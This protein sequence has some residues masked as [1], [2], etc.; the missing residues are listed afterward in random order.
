MSQRCHLAQIIFVSLLQIN[1]A[2]AILSLYE[3]TL[4]RGCV[5]GQE[6]PPVRVFNLIRKKSRIILGGKIVVIEFHL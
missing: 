6:K 5:T 4:S 1:I 3:I 2:S